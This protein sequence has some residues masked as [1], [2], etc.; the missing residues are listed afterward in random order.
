MPLINKTKNKTIIDNVRIAGNFFSQVRGLMFEDKKKF[1]YALVF[2]QAVESR[3]GTSVH[4]LFVFFP[5]DIVFLDSDKRVVDVRR[6]VP[7]FLP[8]LAPKKS[9]KYF[10]EMPVGKSSGIEEGDI[11]EW[12]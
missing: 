11:I 4:M 10:I 3:H 9:A 1:N 6:N 12:S 5:I 7:S 8:Y 2:P